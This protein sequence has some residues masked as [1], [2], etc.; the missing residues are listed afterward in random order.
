MW[1][2]AANPTSVN[3]QPLGVGWQHTYLTYVDTYTIAM[4]KYVLLHTSQGRDVLYTYLS[5]SAGWDTYTPQYGDHVMSLKVNTASPFQT[6]VQLLTGETIVYNSSGQLSEIW[7]TL[8][9][10]P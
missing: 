8:A 6:Q 7:D 4:V 10:T 2:P 5:T 1:A 3:K 9:P